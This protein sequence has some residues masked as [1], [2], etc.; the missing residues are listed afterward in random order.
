[1]NREQVPALPAERGRSAARLPAQH[2]VVARRFS[3][4]VYIYTCM[5]HYTTVYF[6]FKQRGE[7]ISGIILRLS[8]IFG[9]GWHGIC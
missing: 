2:D 7:I 4:L 6:G 9:D 1:M 5:H 3:S 8:S